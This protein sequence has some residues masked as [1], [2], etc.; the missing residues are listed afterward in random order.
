MRN[1]KFFLP[2]FVSFVLNNSLNAQCTIA[3][4]S[5]S[6]TGQ[7]VSTIGH[8]VG[9]TFQ[10]CETGSITRLTINFGVSTG[11]TDPGTHELR[12]GSTT[13]PPTTTVGG[14]VYQL[15]N[16]GS[17]VQT[18]TIDL[19]NPFPVVAGNQYAFDVTA[20]SDLY[21]ILDD[22][23]DIPNASFY[24]H[25]GVSLFTIP[26]SNLEF[27]VQIV[28]APVPTLSEWGLIILALLLM[29]F[30]TLYLVQPNWRGR[31]E[32]EG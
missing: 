3:V 9:N 14:S 7:G 25:F 32:Q 24:S 18:V 16:T 23:P 13:E 22:S 20:G 29:T 27:T 12:I 8:I 26:T 31:F 4:T 6:T 2:I 19:T 11:T 28:P 15:F 10:A 30:G 21:F 5:S 1:F 17:G